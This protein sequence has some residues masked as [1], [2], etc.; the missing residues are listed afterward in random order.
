MQKSCG[1]N[2]RPKPQIW[3]HTSATGLLEAWELFPALC[4]DLGSLSCGSTT[5]GSPEHK[6]QD[7]EGEA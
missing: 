6:A 3:L 5:Q 1:H 2:Q 4:T 7:P